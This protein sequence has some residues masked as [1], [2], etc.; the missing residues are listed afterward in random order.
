VSRAVGALRAWLSGPIAFGLAQLALLLT[1]LATTLQPGYRGGRFVVVVL[2]MTLLVQVIALL[3]DGQA[4]RRQ[5]AGR[6]RAPSPPFLRIALV[7]ACGLALCYAI[8]F[9]AS[10]TV[11]LF[12]VWR[13]A[14]GF[15]V[16]RSATLAV[17]VGAAL[18]LAFTGLLAL[19]PWRGV[20]DVG[21]PW[22]IGGSIAPPW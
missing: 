13:L 15:G 21:L 22:L 11:M 2:A 18:P 4:A 19:T 16:L 17:I 20:V 12:L 8:G 6:D 3:R 10:F 7:A 5:P 1:L 14:C 9:V